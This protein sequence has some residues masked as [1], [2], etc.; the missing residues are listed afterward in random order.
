MILDEATSALDA[1][2]EREVMT[3]VQR[4]RGSRTILMIAHRLSTVRNTDVILVMKD[5]RIVEHGSHAELVQKR[6]RMMI[7]GL[8]T[9]GLNASQA[10]NSDLR[11]IL[12]NFLNGGDTTEFGMVMP[13]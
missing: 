12:D 10:S 2:S 8:A 7:N 4:L 3:H 13:V 5:G 6:V 11:V 1:L 9:C